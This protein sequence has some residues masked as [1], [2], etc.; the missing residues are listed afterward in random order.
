V[1]TSRP[2]RSELREQQAERTRRLIASAARA[3]FLE[4][5]WS[6]TSVR[7]VA[8]GA[9][10]SEATVYAVYGSKAGLASSLIDAAELSAD[11]DRVVAELRERSGDPVAQ[12]RSFVAFDRRLFEHGGDVIRLVA[13]A[14]RQHPDLGAANEEGRRRGE[15]E[16]ATVFSSWPGRVWR[17]GVDV[18]RA[19]AVYALLV[20]LEA[21]DIA[22]GERG[23]SS[24]E[25]ERWWHA[26]L[27][28]LLMT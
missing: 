28:E 2:Y 15:T 24:D 4:R 21:Y 5:G 12:L 14:R 13:E 8:A 19:L 20:S 22:T 27:V 6:G 26:T 16:R 25:V 10:V 18:G 3:R 7:S 9:G 1:S 11:V 17:P 23:W